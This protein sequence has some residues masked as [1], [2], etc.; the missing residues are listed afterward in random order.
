MSRSEGW[1][2]VFN[3]IT[4]DYNKESMF[5]HRKFTSSV[6]GLNPGSLAQEA[7]A[8]FTELPP[9]YIIRKSCTLV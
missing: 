6:A 4:A 9:S 1:H 7:N 3:V 2:T 8:L 5:R